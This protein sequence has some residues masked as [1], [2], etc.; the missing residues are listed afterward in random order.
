[1]NEHEAFALAEFVHDH[2]KRFKAKAKPDGD[3]SAVLLTLVADGTPLPAV[4]DWGEYRQRCIE[5]D[6]P[7]P[8]VRAAWDKWNQGQSGSSSGQ[9]TV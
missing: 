1:M 2:D 8:T 7:G 4:S 3:Q 6:D 9:S 5:T